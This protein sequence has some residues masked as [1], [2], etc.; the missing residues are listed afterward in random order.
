MPNVASGTEFVQP[1]LP[2]AYRSSLASLR[3]G[4]VGGGVRKA[5]FLPLYVRRPECPGT[6]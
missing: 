2:A 1:V 3:A 5:H 4:S 6:L